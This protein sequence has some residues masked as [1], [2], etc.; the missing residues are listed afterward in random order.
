[1]LQNRLRSAIVH[2]WPRPIDPAVVALRRETIDMMG[3]PQKLRER[4]VD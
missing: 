3:E 4:I 2:A 1:L